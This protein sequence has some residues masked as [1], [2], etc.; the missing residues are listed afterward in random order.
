MVQASYG[1]G[2]DLAKAERETPLSNVVAGV[3]IKD[4]TEIVE[5]PADR[6]A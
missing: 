3:T 5:V 1:G 2:Q 6:A 4:G